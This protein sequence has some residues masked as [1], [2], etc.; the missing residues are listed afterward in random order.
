MAQTQEFYRLAG[1]NPRFTT[2]LNAF[3]NGMYLTNQVIPEGYVKAMVNYDIDDTG[4]NIKPKRGR[5]L[6]QSVGDYTAELGPVTLTD[7]IYAYNAEGTEVESTKDIVLSHGALYKVSELVE[8]TDYDPNKHLYVGA[9]ERTVDNTVYEKIDDE[10]VK[11]SDGWEEYSNRKPFWALYYDTANEKFT[12]IENANIGY[13]AA[14]SI[15]NIYAFNK[16]FRDSVARPISTVLNNEIITFSGDKIVINE[17]TANPE[18]NEIIN[19]GAPD[20]TKLI[21]VNEGDRYSIKRKVIEPRVLNPIEALSSG[22]NI[23]HPE[24]YVFE[25]EPGGTIAILGMLLYEDELSSAP[26]FSP[27]LGKA[28]TV[29]TYYQYPDLEDSDPTKIQYKIEILNA[30]STSEDWEVIKAFPEADD[31]DQGIVPGDKLLHTFIPKYKSFLYRVTLRLGDDEKTEYPYFILI[32]CGDSTYDNLKNKTFDLR[33]CKGM[34]SWQ[35]CVGVYGLPE[36]PNTIFFSDV[37]DPS[38]FPFPNNTMAFD[39]DILAVHNYLDNLVVVTI[40]SIWLVVAGT[41]INTSIQKRILANIHIPEIDA[42]NLVVLKDQIFFKTDTQFYVLKPNQ[43]TSDATDLKNYVN[44]TAIANYTADFKKETVNLLNKVYVEMLQEMER[45]YPNSDFKFVDFD[46]LDTVS[47]IRDSEVHY[48]YTIVPIL[49]DQYPFFFQEHRLNLHLVYNT[50]SRSWRMYFVTIGDDD[51]RYNPVLYKNKQ[52]GAFYEFFTHPGDDEYTV[53]ITKQT[54]ERVSDIVTDGKWTLAKYYD[55]YTYI[56]TGN[57]ALDDV[58]TKRFREAQFNLL[59]LNGKAIRFYTNFFV[60]GQE[61]V[62]A[63]NYEVQHITDPDDYDYGKIYVTPI[64]QSNLVLP[65]ATELAD[66]ETEINHWT[67]DSSKF[68]DL[69]LTTVRYQLQ[70]RGYRCS[71]QLLNTSLQR[72]ELSELKWIYRIMSSR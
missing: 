68:P 14:R 55:N 52:S 11:V 22:Y 40:D 46:V 28:V 4:S 5:E 38:Y 15:N 61:Y 3:A 8:Q 56:D 6:V 50:L 27:E 20:L 44:S 72:Y 51:T 36:A 42:I 16:A 35:S 24:P 33:N 69:A 49:S 67:L 70:G 43:Y 21:L 62:D 9:I 13:V 18:R 39:N 45:D 10:W 32:E 66:V 12:P 2:K 47:L 7:Y 37:E 48:I 71:L 57:V 41:T 26:V 53:T 58:S 34:I 64:E 30:Q 54:Y 29:R 1:R 17:F 59:N 19:F 31:E 23:L 60:D 63:T 25:D 65:G